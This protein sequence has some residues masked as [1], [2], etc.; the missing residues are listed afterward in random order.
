MFLYG[1]I[2]M[3]IYGIGKYIVKIYSNRKIYSIGNNKGK[4]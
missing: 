2:Y 3:F 1:T 4:R